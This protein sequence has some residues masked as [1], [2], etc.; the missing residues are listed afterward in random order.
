[1]V[2]MEKVVIVGAN[3]AGKLI[4]DIIFKRRYML[5]E[6]IHVVGF[7]DDD[8]SL[9]GQCIHGV[10]ILGT[11]ESF[12]EKEIDES[13]QFIV[14]TDEV[15]VKKHIIKQIENKG[16]SDFYI[17]VHPRAVVGNNVS[18][19]VGT[20]V[21][22][23]AIINIDTELGEHVVVGA[24]SMIEIGSQIGDHVVIK[25][26]CIVGEDVRIGDHALLQ[27]GTITGDN[28]RIPKAYRSKLGEIIE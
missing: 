19:G 4:L 24:G 15:S 22:S 16:Y 1:M 27:A 23:G 14:A 7:L 3:N 10:E 25:P 5:L 11:L 17:A 26:K 18:V 9:H 13:L 20:I 12:L 8:C 6:D 21:H 2:T 28:V